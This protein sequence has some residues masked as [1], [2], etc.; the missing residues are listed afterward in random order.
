M[1]ESPE[2]ILIGRNNGPSLILEQLNQSFKILTGQMR[3]F[4]L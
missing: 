2:I 1:L 3:M 4:D